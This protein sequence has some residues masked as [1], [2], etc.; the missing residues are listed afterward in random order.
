MTAI[1]IG[2][3]INLTSK[4][5]LLSNENINK[6]INNLAEFAKSTFNPLHNPIFIYK[7]VEKFDLKES[8]RSIEELLELWIDDAVKDNL[9]GFFN[10]DYDLR[11]LSV[12]NTFKRL[13]INAVFTINGDLIE[14]SIPDKIAS[15]LLTYESVFTTNYHEFW[16]NSK[17]VIYLHGKIDYVNFKQNT[18]NEI[19]YSKDIEYISMQEDKNAF[20][21]YFPIKNIDD[22]IMLPLKSKFNKNIIHQ[23]QKAKKTNY[24]YSEFKE[25]KK[26]NI[27]A[28]LSSLES[29]DVFG[30]SPFGDELIIDALKH[31]K[32]LRVYVYQLNSLSGKEEA[33]QWQKNLPNEELLDS[34]LFL[35]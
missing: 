28:E 8:R 17:E 9:D 4:N 30:F 7:A 26:E 10:T 16:T 18:M 21:L 13:I 5:D 24:D 1:L 15:K 27:Y 2:N 6:R 19:D 12:I 34:S 32:N 23:L 25:I 3:G 35:G 29:L 20:D 11:V 14:L 31:I 33:I 22:V